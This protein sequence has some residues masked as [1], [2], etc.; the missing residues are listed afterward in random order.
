MNVE[1]RDVP[2]DWAT[3]VVMSSSTPSSIFIHI[4]E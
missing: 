2:L 3:P 4:D 1:V